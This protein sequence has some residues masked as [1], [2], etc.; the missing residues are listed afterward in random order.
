MSDR[1]AERL[2]LPVG[3]IEGHDTGT[4]GMWTLIATEAALFAYLLFGYYYFAAQFGH[5]W[6]PSKL[7]EFR[8]ALPN[9]VILLAS[10]AA[11]WWGERGVKRNSTLQLAA[12]L[13]IALLLGLIFLGIQLFEWRS[14]DFA[15]WTSSYGSFYFITTGFHMAHVAAGLLMLLGVLVWGLLGYFDARRHTPVSIA[16][17]YWHFVDAVWLA[18]FFTYYV[19]PRLG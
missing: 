15:P 7:P 2:P 10:S 4:W 13:G 14:K 5:A 9:T 16:A 6:L 19:T 1:S 11:A 3:S 18:V 12:G 8:L 17:V